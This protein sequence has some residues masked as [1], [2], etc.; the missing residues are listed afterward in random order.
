[1]SVEVKETGENVFNLERFPTD[2]LG[3]REKTKGIKEMCIQALE[4]FYTQLTKTFLLLFLI[5]SLRSLL[6]ALITSEN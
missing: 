4:G 3:E 6:R 2:W 5:T 1:M